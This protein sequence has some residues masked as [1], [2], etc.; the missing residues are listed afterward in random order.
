MRSAAV[1]EQQAA[2]P[3]HDNAAAWLVHLRRALEGLD[4]RPGARAGLAAD[5]ESYLL[6]GEPRAVLGEAA[7]LS[8]V[9]SQLHLDVDREEAGRDELGRFYQALCQAGS[10][11]GLRWAHLLE[12]AGTDAGVECYGIVMPDGSH[13]AEALMTHARGLICRGLRW[14]TPAMRGLSAA[15]VEGLL[16]EAGLAADALLLGVFGTPAEHNFHTGHRVPGVTE[17]EG[18]ADYVQRHVESVRPLLD[19]G[20]TKR[21]VMSME[22]LRPCGDATLASLAPELAGLATCGSKQVRVAAEPLARRAAIAVSPELVRLAT[23]GK[24]DQRLHA[25]RLLRQVG[26]DRGDAALMEQA[27]GLA[28]A[29]KA[30]TVQALLGEWE[31]AAVPHSDACAYTMPVIGWSTALTPE[32]DAAL[33]ALWA[34]IGERIVLRNQERT[35]WHAKSAARGH[36]WKLELEPPLPASSLERLRAYL[37]EAG[38]AGRP[39]AGICELHFSS[40]ALA[41]FA[42]QPGVTPAV[43]AKTAMTFT[44]KRDVLLNSNVTPAFDALYRA[45]GHPT[46]LEYQLLAEGAGST[47]RDVLDNYCAGWCAVGANMAAEDVWPFLAHNRDLLVQRILSPGDDDYRFERRKLYAALKTFPVLPPQVADA[48]FEL[49]LSSLKSARP[50]AQEA[51]DGFPGKE[52]RITAALA[53]GKAEVRAVAAQWLMRLGHSAAVPQLE[54]AVAKE[55]HDLA[56]GAMLDALQRFGQPVEKYLDRAALLKEAGKT[57]EKGIHKDLAWFPWEHLPAVAWADNSTAVPHEV[58]K[59]LLVQA[60]KQKSPEP[61]AVLR[62]FCVMFAPQGREALGQFVLEAWLEED[63][64]PIPASVAAELAASDGATLLH[65]MQNWPQYY[66]NH[67]LLGRPL[68][69]LVASALPRRLRQPAGSAIASKGLLAIAS[70]CAGGR[71][72]APVAAYLKQWYGTRAAHGKALIAMLAWIDHPGATQLMLSVGNR[73]RTRS[74]QEEAT[75]Q[76]EA[77]AERKGWTLSELADRTIPAGGFD[78]HGV[79]ELSYGERAFTARLMPDFKV[80]LFNPEGK[81][82]GAL[83]EP[84]ADDDAALAKESKAALSAAKK[85]I[86][87]IVKLQGERLYEALCTE[88]DWAFEDWQQYL[89]QHAIVRRLIQR[90]VWVEMQDGVAVR[91]FRPL[92]DG[93]LTDRDDNPVSLA[94]AAR[95]RVAHDSCLPAEEVA[96]WLQHM[97]DYEVAPLFQQLGKGVYSLPQGQQDATGIEDHK[98]HMIETFALRNRALKLGYTR[99]A[100]EDGGWFYV[101]EKRFP[102]QGVTALIEF[103]GNGLPEENRKVAL[104]KVAFAGPGGGR[105]GAAGLPL[106]SIPKVLIS[107]CYNDMRLIASDGSGFH[108]DWQSLSNY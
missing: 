81:A 44:E 79:L 57:L 34:S 39:G 13:W 68:P 52:A 15:G 6:R 105:G 8:P 89:N 4:Q 104:L 17:L 84:R 48:L 82:I 18:Y 49:A 65:G 61:N 96:G 66:E 74:F 3:D 88:R 19:A 98:G 16:T 91:S 47:A 108:A 22:L 87:G 94:P 24:P 42:V 46:L 55:K 32:L 41:T 21:R 75:L 35:E 76:A 7:W 38:I 95:I 85:E 54:A 40:D 23:S 5:I 58:L 73:F 33:E 31:S 30:A 92:D 12:S 64:R 103:T 36:N 72:A 78:E 71:A 50:G 60:F 10:A 99:G 67:P 83:P 101:Y 26:A 93:T 27:R 20:D 2:P 77:L 106:S 51:L 11:T 69:D 28:A 14:P 100:A 63:V 29:D 9:S 45:T 59:L 43:L 37:A 80:E 90:L 70:A 1:Q 97:A 53:S 25:L 62:K 102:T 86:K 107:E 56:K